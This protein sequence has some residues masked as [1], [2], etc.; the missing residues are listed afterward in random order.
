MSHPQCFLPN[1]HKTEILVASSRIQDFLSFPPRLVCWHQP[2]PFDS[3]EKSTKSSV[4]ILLGKFKQRHSKS[5]ILYLARIIDHISRRPSTCY[6]LQTSDHLHAFFHK[7]NIDLKHKST[8]SW[9]I[10]WAKKKWEQGTKDSRIH[11]IR[12]RDIWSMFW[13]VWSHGGVRPI[14]IHHCILP[15]RKVRISLHERTRKATSM[16]R[17]G[18]L[19]SLFLFFRRWSLRVQH[20]NIITKWKYGKGAYKMKYNLTSEGK[21]DTKVTRIPTRQ[22][23]S[24]V[25][26]KSR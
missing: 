12:P 6:Q 10:Q 1:L 4:R 2:M 11:R 13:P 24:W 22:P 14:R 19:F 21:R 23:C 7:I 5:I 3:L 25:W 26:M 17:M 8:K 18:V 15:S 9:A 16:A 20:T